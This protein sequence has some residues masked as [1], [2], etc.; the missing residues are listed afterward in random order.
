MA[1]FCIAPYQL[2]SVVLSC[3]FVAD[4]EAALNTIFTSV[5]KADDATGVCGVNGAYA[6]GCREY[7]KIIPAEMG[8]QAAAMNDKVEFALISNTAH[9]Q[10]WKTQLLTYKEARI[11]TD[12]QP[13]PS[14]R[15]SKLIELVPMKFSQRIRRVDVMSSLAALTAASTMG[16]L[17]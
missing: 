9:F 1:R 16:K 13:K 2:L 17:A 7:D 4:Y 14:S 15:L 11:L 3:F 6:L 5:S 10:C 8:R 12:G